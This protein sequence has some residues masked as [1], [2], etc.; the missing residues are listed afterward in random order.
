[1][2]TAVIKVVVASTKQMM[3]SVQV[4]I[5]N[6]TEASLALHKTALAPRPP[7]PAVVSLLRMNYYEHD[8]NAQYSRRE[9]I[10]IH[11]VATDKDESN[12]QCETRAIEVL[13]DAGVKLE[14][15]DISAVHRA[16][17][18]KDGK[19][20][21]LVKFVSRKT[22]EDVMKMKKN[23]QDM[24]GY[25]GVFITDDLTPMRRTLLWYIKKHVAGVDKAWTVD[26]KIKVQMLRKVRQKDRSNIYVIE[27]PDDLGIIGVKD[28]DYKK[29]KLEHLEFSG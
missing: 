2:T 5:T 3:E 28:I 22:R 11:G 9:S 20:P 27:N 7:D 29:L 23:L 15:R 26:G 14:R 24:E 6:M 8:R 4:A 21:I 13:Q 25:D 18:E 19:Q 16:G 10:R 1:M 17:R 12:F